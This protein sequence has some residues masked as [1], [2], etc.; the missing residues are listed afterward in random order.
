M[1]KLRTNKGFT[2]VEVM[3]ALLISAFVAIGIAGITHVSRQAFLNTRDVVESQQTVIFGMDLMIR[4][5]RQAISISNQV[6]NSLTFIIRINGVNTKVTYRLNGTDLERG[7]DDT[8]FQKVAQ[9]VSLLQ[10][11]YSN[12]LVTINMK[13]DVN[14]KLVQIQNAVTMRNPNL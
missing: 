4:E 10:C 9:Q 3:L 14:G 5:I 11:E 7:V 8:N 1:D 2:L 13:G 12:N 6:V